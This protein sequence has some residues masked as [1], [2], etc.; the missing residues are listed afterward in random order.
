MNWK[1]KY[2]GQN[3]HARQG[4]KAFIYAIRR[5][6]NIISCWFWVELKL[7]ILMSNFRFSLSCL[8]QRSRSLHAAVRSSLYRSEIR[9]VSEDDDHEWDTFSKMM[10]NCQRDYSKHRPTRVPTT[11]WN[12]RLMTCSHLRI[13]QQRFKFCYCI[14]MPLVN[15]IQEWFVIRC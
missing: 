4:K 14:M 8:L 7:E 15:T 13:T 5:S 3:M 9:N 10:W 12:R 6:Y 1:W 11:K 2:I